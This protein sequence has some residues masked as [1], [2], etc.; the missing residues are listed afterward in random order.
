MNIKEK[1][2]LI[3]IYCGDGKGKSTASIGLS[4][5]AA[6][7]NLNVVF[8]Q[9]LKTWPTG[10]LSCLE[11]FDN[12][13]II[14]N[15]K[16]FPFTYKMTDE[17]KSEITLI[18]DEIL[19]NAIAL[20]NEGK[21]DLLVLDEIISTYNLELISKNKVDDFLKNKPKNIEI[22]MTGRDPSP[23][24]VELADYVSEVK[25]VK[26]PYDKGIE[27]RTGIEK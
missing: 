16:P 1:L 23:H 14:K 24:L 22:V 5:R 11:K 4:M 19:N 10:E 7:N 8:T 18:H 27:E 20:C 3:H 6:G 21:C 17:Q 12:I 2:G 15:S 26:H 13:K 25:K 9:F